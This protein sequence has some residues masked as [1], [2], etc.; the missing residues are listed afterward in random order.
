MRFPVNAWLNAHYLH[1]IAI[2]AGFALRWGAMQFMANA[3][4]PSKRKNTK[5]G[6]SSAP[7]PKNKKWH[8][9]RIIKFFTLI[10]VVAAGL[11]LA[12]GAYPFATWAVS[13]GGN[14]GGIASA[15]FG[16]ATIAAGWHALKG[17]VTLAH[18]LTDGTP[19]DEAFDAGFWVPTMIPLGWASLIGLFTNPR[20]VSTG[21]ACVAVSVIT[22][23][24][25]HK[26]LKKTHAAQGHYGMWM[27]VS[28]II[29]VFVG[30]V[31][32][33]ALAYLNQAIGDYLPEWACWLLRAVLIA[34]AVVFLVA[35]LGDWFRDRIP[36][37]WSQWA[38]MYTIPVFSVLTVS[39]AT[40]Q[41]DATTSLHTIFGVL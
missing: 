17:L 41:S 16:T 15:L 18:D 23:A 37:R 35:G 7:A 10:F 5:D 13:W 22:A 8:K 1:L 11:L 33:P 40:L 39:I 28:T 29:C 9:A 31:H 25:A 20:G 4:A 32:I 36:E 19:D 12:Y 14:L 24:Y 26:I 2:G 27:Y 30:L 3:T 21:L 38:A 34:A 6:A